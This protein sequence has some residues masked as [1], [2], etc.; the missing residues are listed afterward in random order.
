MD[1]MTPVHFKMLQNIIFVTFLYCLSNN[2][3]A[4]PFHFFYKTAKKAGFKKKYIN[5][6]SITEKAVIENDKNA[7]NVQSSEN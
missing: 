2:E 4:N 1:G 6:Y 7:L 3:T 5:F